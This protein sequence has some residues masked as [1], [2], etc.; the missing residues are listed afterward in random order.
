MLPTI[1]QSAVFSIISF[2]SNAASA[3]PIAEA[4]VVF[5]QRSSTDP[6]GMITARN[7]WGQQDDSKVLSGRRSRGSAPP[8]ALDPSAPFVLT[9]DRTVADE[10]R[11]CR[12]LS[13]GVRLRRKLLCQRWR[14][15]LGVSQ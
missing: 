5:C 2:M 10:R 13:P 7:A 4:M 14:S 6:S 1:S 12:H 15:G 11:P 3:T 9:L 8:S